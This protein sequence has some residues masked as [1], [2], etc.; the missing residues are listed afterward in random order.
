[1]QKFLTRWLSPTRVI[2]LTA[3]FFAIGGSAFAVGQ[4]TAV[5]QQRCQTGAVKGIAIVRGDPAQGLANLPEQYTSAANLF[6]FRFNCSGRPI[7][8]KRIS[9]TAFDVRFVGTAA[10]AALVTGVGGTPT[11]A[12]VNGMPDGGWRV[13]IGGP[14]AGGAFQPRVDIPFVVTIL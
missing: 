1:M 2:A 13:T 5:A 6:F 10:R 4:K 9:N 7:E 11:A 8:V 14:G 3:L 12:S